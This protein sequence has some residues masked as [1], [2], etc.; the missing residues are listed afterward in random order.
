LTHTAI[1]SSDF[2]GAPKIYPIAPWHENDID[3]ALYGK[4]CVIN[5]EIANY[6]DYCGDERQAFKSYEQI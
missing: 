1:I 3:M 5:T 6:N 2:L 4:T